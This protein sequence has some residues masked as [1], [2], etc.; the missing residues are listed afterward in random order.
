MVCTLRFFVETKISLPAVCFP[1][2]QRYLCFYYFNLFI[3]MKN[4][5]IQAAAFVGSLGLISIFDPCDRKD[6]LSGI[7]LVF[8]SLFLLYTL[9]TPYWNERNHSSYWCDIPR[10]H[11]VVRT[12]LLF[13]HWILVEIGKLNE[14]QDQKENRKTNVPF[15]STIL[16]KVYD[17]LLVRKSSRKR[18][19][20]LLSG[21]RWSLMDVQKHRPNRL[22]KLF[23]CKGYNEC[24]Y[25]KLIQHRYI[26]TFECRCPWYYRLWDSMVKYIHT[27]AVKWRVRLA[28]SAVHSNC[29]WRNSCLNTESMATAY[30]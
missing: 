4:L 2:S 23:R 10:F 24:E 1:F 28:Y 19:F 18:E 11:V 9:S 7:L 15:L 27:S 5:Q 3:E 21:R 29:P 25:I 14:I 20:C 6:F 26:N 22:M 12:Y 8:L 17:S 30:R 16:F 13:V